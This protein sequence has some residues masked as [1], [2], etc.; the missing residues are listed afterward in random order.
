MENWRQYLMEANYSGPPLNYSSVVLNDPNIMLKAAEKLK[1]KDQIPPEFTNKEEKWPHHMTIN[2]GPLL[3]GWENDKPMTLTI[4][5]WGLV[6]DETGP[7]GKPVKAMAFRVDPASLNGLPVK[8]AVPHI[9]TL[10]PPDGK[11]AHS[12]KI[13]NWQDLDFGPFDVEGI[14]VERQAKKKKKKKEKPQRQRPKGQDDPVE[15]AKGLAGRRLK[16]EQIKNIIMN[17]FKLSKDEEGEEEVSKIMR[18]AGIQ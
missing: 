14:V 5:G 6:N 10:V 15:F 8:N 3:P 9:T 16:P 2:M 18:G 12:N 4:N 7:D 1:D 11:P 13:V 17:K